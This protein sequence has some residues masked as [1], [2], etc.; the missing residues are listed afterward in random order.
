MT[1]D[2]NTMIDSTEKISKVGGYRETIKPFIPIII[3]ISFLIKEIIE[4]YKKAQFNKKICNSLLDRAK[5]AETA[6][7][8]LQRRKQ[9]NEKNFLNQSYYN[10]FNFAGEV[11]QI[12]GIDKYL[13]TTSIEDKFLELTSVYD[14]CMEDLHFVFVIAQDEQRRY[15]QKG[16]ESDLAEMSEFLNQFQGESE[17]VQESLKILHQEVSIIKTQLS[18]PIQISAPR[19]DPKHLTDIENEEKLL[20]TVENSS[21]IMVVKKLYKNA[22]VSCNKIGFQTQGL[23]AILGKLNECPNI[24]KFFGMT[25]R[26]E[27]KLANFHFEKVLNHSETIFNDG[28]L[29]FVHW[30]APEKMY[31]YMCL[32]ARRQE[33]TQQCEIFSFG[34]MLWELC[35]ERVPYHCKDT[36]YITN[37]V[38]KAGRERI[39]VYSGSKEDKEIY[40]E[41]I[42]IIKMAWAHDPDERISINKVLKLDEGISEES[43]MSDDEDLY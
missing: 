2:L 1:D 29:N 13:N 31:E 34:M 39:P 33:Y 4:I 25:S 36:G 24:F 28:I 26:L 20:K 27:P 43:V 19:I 41:F 8:T 10:N 21:N 42:K 14:K 17:I 32:N 37:H 16:L 6:M 18:H 22:I 40:F 11:T 5:S 12:R 23:L 15:D 38:T 35:F 3:T 9:E 30:L 7:N